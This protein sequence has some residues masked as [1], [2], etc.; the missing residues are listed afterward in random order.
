MAGIISLR[1]I[2][3]MSLFIGALRIIQFSWFQ[4]LIISAVIMSLTM[5]RVLERVKIGAIVLSFVWA[6]G[7]MLGE[8]ETF[9]VVASTSFQDGQE[10]R[11]LS[12]QNALVQF[13]RKKISRDQDGESGPSQNDNKKEGIKPVAISEDYKEQINAVD[14]LAR[15]G[16]I[17]KEEVDRIKEQITTRYLSQGTT[18]T[19]TS[20]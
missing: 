19:T 2:V 16:A 5:M 14:L 3:F 15:S 10:S 7:I 9:P 13:I 8:V 20:N 11:S 6:A 17:K 18:P 1:S 4:S 12:S